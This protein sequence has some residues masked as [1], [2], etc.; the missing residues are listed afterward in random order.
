MQASILRIL[1]ANANRAREALRVI[2]DYARFS[3]D[4]KQ[5]C[6]ELK[7][8]RHDLTQTLAPVVSEAILHR[9]TPRDVGTDTKTDAEMQRSGVFVVITAAGKRLGE[10]LRVLEE[11][12]KIDR[13]E[14]AREV[15]AIRY[16]F[17]DMEL[18]IARTLRRRDLFERVRLYV[19]ITESLC[20]RSW[21]ETAEQ[22]IA[23]GAAVR[24]G[25]PVAETAPAVDV[26]A[27]AVENATGNVQPTTPV[28][29]GSL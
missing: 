13:P 14:A 17:Y 1:D 11:Y 4:D 2:E 10:A 6:A 20:R 26:N 18:R 25:A 3:L 15:E 7:R 29:N 5:L 16:R 27:G 9:D 12:L 8:L 23:G 28:L 22:A 24:R 19:L 21:L